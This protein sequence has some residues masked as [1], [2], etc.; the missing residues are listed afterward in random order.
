MSCI[1]EVTKARLGSSLVLVVAALIVV[2]APTMASAATVGTPLPA[3]TYDAPTHVY[4][5]SSKYGRAS[6]AA[7]YRDNANR[8]SWTPATAA[9]LRSSQ[10]GVAVNSADGLARLT[11][12]QQ[13]SLRSLQSQVQKHQEKLDDYRA[14]PDE[15]DNLGILGR[16]PTPEIRQRII[17]GRIR[18]LE[19]EIQTFQDQI[20][21]LLGG[22]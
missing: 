5:G 1:V 11:T 18:R 10:V 8:S 21:K 2:L 13:R 19:T 6:S 12:T 3:S 4:G 9:L 7:G 16:A 20:D 14:N 22:G 15:Y 17:D